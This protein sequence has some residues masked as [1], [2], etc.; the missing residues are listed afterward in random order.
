MRALGRA[1]EPLR[2]DEESAE[3]LYPSC[4]PN[5][6][7]IPPAR[8][9]PPNPRLAS[10]RPR[11]TPA[12]RRSRVIGSA[13]PDIEFRG[14]SKR[15]GAVTAVQGIDLAVPRGAFVALLGPSGC[16]KTTRL[17]VIGGS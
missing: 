12:S 4:C 9:R 15:Y 8:Y 2:R 14:I 11:L 16:G 1:I 7:Y 5:R 13:P 3:I 17:P 6:Q 10:L